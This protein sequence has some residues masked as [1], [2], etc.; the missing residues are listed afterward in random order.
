VPVGRLSKPKLPEK[1]QDAVPKRNW[2]V[3]C[4]ADFVMPLHVRDVS[5]A[6]PGL[7][8]KP[9]TLIVELGFG[10]PQVTASNKEPTFFPPVNPVGE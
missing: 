9:V 4:A 3:A 10:V 1:F 8:E 7:D 5:H 2:K 6:L